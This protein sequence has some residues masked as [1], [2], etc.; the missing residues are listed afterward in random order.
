MSKSQNTIK[1]GNFRGL[2]F[3]E[4]NVWHGIALELNISV[5]G[6]TEIEVQNELRKAVEGY[7]EAITKEKFS[8][9][10]LNQKPNKIYEK[11]W[12]AII[13][14][15]KKKPIKSPLSFAGVF[16]LDTYA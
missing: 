5:V 14:M 4:G 10:L 7:I 13:E 9:N 1:Q 3:K 2:F 11:M 8:N 6:K 12:T 16:S 15:K